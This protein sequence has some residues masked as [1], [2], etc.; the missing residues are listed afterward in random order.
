MLHAPRARRYCTCE[1]RSNLERGGA[2]SVEV[3]VDEGLEAELAVKLA[4]AVAVLARI[5]RGGGTSPSAEAAEAGTPRE[6]VEAVLRQR[7]REIVGDALT[8]GTQEAAR[9]LGLPLSN[10]DRALRDGNIPHVTVGRRRRIA[11]DVLVALLLG[12]AA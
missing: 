7:I 5:A 1:T 10:I 2:T 11:V 3:T 9:V 8:V 4:A 6:D 12:R